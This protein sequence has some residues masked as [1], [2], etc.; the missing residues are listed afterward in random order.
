[1]ANL[2]ELKE[3]YTEALEGAIDENGEIIES[4]L[5]DLLG[6]I[7]EAIETKLVNIA[8]LVKNLVAESDALKAEETTL[9]TRR[10]AKDKKIDVLE[11][12]L[13]FGMGDRAK[14]EAPR[15]VISFCKS[16]VVEVTAGADMLFKIRPDLI[17]TKFEPDK[18]A[19][20]KAI[21]SG[22]L[23]VGCEIVNKRNVVIK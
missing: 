1:M 11:K 14:L 4:R 17:R 8:C 19:I 9:A 6:D 23:I 2:Y 7:D 12:Y 20:K 21:E 18:T 13:V 16:S 22:E 3:L 15:A 5:V 10:K